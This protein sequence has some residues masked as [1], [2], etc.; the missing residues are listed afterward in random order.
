MKFESYAF[1]LTSLM[2]QASAPTFKPSERTIGELLNPPAD[3]EYYKRYADRF[4]AEI[5]D[6][7]AVALYPLAF[8]MIVFVFLGEARTTRQSRHTGVLGA[9][10]GCVLVRVAGF[11]ASNMAVADP[12]LVFAIYLVP[13]GV[14]LIGARLAL[15]DTRPVWMRVVGRAVHGIVAAVETA[16]ERL[17]ARLANG[18]T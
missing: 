3:D 16:A 15:A 9:L 10:F 8:G 14:I 1:D 5:H 2:P 12:N 6:R 17:T 18:R 4:H 7:F 11:G 13:L